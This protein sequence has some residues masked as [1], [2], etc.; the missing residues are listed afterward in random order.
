MK[1]LPLEV[2][3]DRNGY[4]RKVS[5]DEHAG[6]QQAAKVTMELHDFGAPVAIKPRRATPSST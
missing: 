1:N 3:V 6:R 4:I 5:Y 2:W